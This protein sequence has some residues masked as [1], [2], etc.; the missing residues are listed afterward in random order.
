M[1]EIGSVVIPNPPDSDYVYYVLDGQQRI[2]SLYVSVKGCAVNLGNETTED[3]SSITVDLTAEDDDRIVYATPDAEVLNPDSS[4]S[5]SSLVSSDILPLVEK[6][7][8]YIKK[9]DDYRK[10]LNGQY[11]FSKIDF[12]DATINVATEVFTRLNI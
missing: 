12:E 1:R 2:T 6:Y 10:L 3:Y 5:L 9:I 4:I 11:R 8:A 7:G